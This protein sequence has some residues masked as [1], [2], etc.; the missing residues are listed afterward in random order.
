MASGFQAEHRG[1]GQIS[2]DAS[3]KFVCV[4]N[5]TDKYFAG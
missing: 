5:H 1:G 3:A 4:E 2:P